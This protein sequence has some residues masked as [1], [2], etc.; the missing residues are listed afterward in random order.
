VCVVRHRVKKS[1]VG[2]IGGRH[3]KMYKDSNRAA[4]RREGK[5]KRKEQAKGVKAERG[6][7]SSTD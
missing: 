7:G 4:V 2:T 1:V 3:R 5:R 6:A